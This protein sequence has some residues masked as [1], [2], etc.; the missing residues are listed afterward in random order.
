MERLYLSAPE[1]PS[2]RLWRVTAYPVPAGAHVP[3][4]RYPAYTPEEALANASKSHP[5]PGEAVGWLYLVSDTP[6]APVPSTTAD[7]PTWN[8]VTA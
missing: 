5:T 8:E 6:G 3:L 2:L 4:G 7:L 1:A